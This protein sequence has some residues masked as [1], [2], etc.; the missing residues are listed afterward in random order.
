MDEHEYPGLEILARFPSVEV[1]KRARGGYDS[2][3]HYCP[4]LGDV[5][6]RTTPDDRLAADE[7][8]D[9]HRRRVTHHGSGP[10]D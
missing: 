10:D 5:A 7:I 4:P 9:S 3:K 2:R 6:D 1:V 8:D